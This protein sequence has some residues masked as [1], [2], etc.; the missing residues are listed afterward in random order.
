MNKQITCLVCPRG[1]RLTVTPDLEVTGNMCARGIPYAKQE[2]TNP[3]RTLTY[4]VRVKGQKAP[5]P[6]RTDVP[7]A[8]SLIFDVVKLLKT[9]E[10]SAPLAFNAVIVENI[11]D[12]GANIITS[13][14]L[15]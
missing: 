14:K 7:I 4:V 6:V 3:K 5:L 15:D 13:Q 11:L 12:S 2:M 10:V 1:C 8:K 9:I